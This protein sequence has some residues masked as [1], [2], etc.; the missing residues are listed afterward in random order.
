[1]LCKRNVSVYQ[2]FQGL[3]RIFQKREHV[4]DVPVV[5]DALYDL[6]SDSTHVSDPHEVVEE[7]VENSGELREL[8]KPGDSPFFEVMNVYLTALFE[9]LDEGI[10]FVNKFEELKDFSPAR[11]IVFNQ[12]GGSDSVDQVHLHVVPIQLGR[13]HAFNVK[14]YDVLIKGKHFISA[15]AG[16]HDVRIDDHVRFYFSKYNPRDLR[17]Q[18]KGHL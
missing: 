4:L 12:L 17:G 9:Q 16:S 3:T 18:L 1:M 7:V 6:F 15:F 11:N 13:R 8:G 14:V 10:V 5:N 2:A